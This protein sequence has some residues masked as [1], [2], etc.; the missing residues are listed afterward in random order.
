VGNFDRVWRWRRSALHHD[1]FQIGKHRL[2]P[3]L[4]EIARR[5]NVQNVLAARAETWMVKISV[6]RGG[7]FARG[8]VRHFF[9]HA[10]I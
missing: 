10:L 3:S 8:C 1:F 9:H 6:S 2:L 7:N 5:Q 4:V